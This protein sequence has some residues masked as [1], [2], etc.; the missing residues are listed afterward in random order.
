MNDLTKRLPCVLQWPQRLIVIAVLSVAATTTGCSVLAPFNSSSCSC[1]DDC[2]GESTDGCT[3]GMPCETHSSQEI[4]Y[5]QNLPMFSNNT[6]P[7]AAAPS[8]AE[9][10]APRHNVMA[11]PANAS[12]DRQLQEIRQDFQDKLT[13]LE[14]RFEKE[15]RANDAINDQLQVLHGDVVRLSNE[16]DYWK[17]EVSRIDRAN[18]MNHKSEMVNLNSISEVIEKMVSDSALGE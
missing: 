9:Q 4:Q 13:T 17:N 14:L 16:L 11:Q 18:E 3:A 7:V 6:M 5:P 1:R 8:R 2:C 10:W 15:H 12:C